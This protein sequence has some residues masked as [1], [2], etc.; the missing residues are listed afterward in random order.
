MIWSPARKV[1][2]VGVRHF[3]EVVVGNG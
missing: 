3:G 1:Q 2:V